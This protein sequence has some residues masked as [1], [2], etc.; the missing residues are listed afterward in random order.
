[1]TLLLFFC[2][3]L[4]SIATLLPMSRH[5][6]WLVR[7]LDFPR[8]QIGILA[9]LLLITHVFFSDKHATISWALLAVTTICVFWHLWW[10]LPYTF[11]W[12]KE[13]ID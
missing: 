13:V 2:T 12:P 3:V 6:H 1:M 4:I 11:V 9:A 5:L 10:K 7:G 8:L